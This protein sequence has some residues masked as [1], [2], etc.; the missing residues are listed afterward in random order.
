ME[1]SLELAGTEDWQQVNW[2]RPVLFD[3]RRIFECSACGKMLQCVAYCHHHVRSKDH[4][5]RLERA[6]GSLRYGG[7]SLRECPER[8]VV[9]ASPGLPVAAPGVAW[10]P[11][12]VVPDD[13]FEGDGSEDSDHFTAERIARDPWDRGMFGS[14]RGLPPGRVGSQPPVEERACG[15]ACGFRSGGVGSEPLASVAGPG[16]PPGVL[17]DA[18]GC[19]P[20][21]GSFGEPLLWPA[22][23]LRAELQLDAP[24]HALEGSPLPSLASPAA[25]SAPPR[26]R[27]E[28]RSVAFELPT[29]PEDPS[30]VSRGEEEVLEEF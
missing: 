18:S 1:F 6:Y 27:P 26:R 19:S 11:D 13:A 29:S 10:S 14:L 4:W 5:R 9:D 16:C 8:M 15:S 17:L 28:R 20:S 2:I 21:R 30:I 25:S 24:T 23:R 12:V 22:P 3:G 7:I